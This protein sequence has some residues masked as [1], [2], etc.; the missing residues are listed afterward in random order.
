MRPFQKLIVEYRLF[1]DVIELVIP[2]SIADSYYRN[3]ER[4]VM[5]PFMQLLQKISA[6]IFLGAAFFVSGCTND[7]TATGEGDSTVVTAA[8][9]APSAAPGTNIVSGNRVLLTW[10]V[11][12]G[13]ADYRMHRGVQADGSDRGESP[14]ATV[15]STHYTDVGLTTGTSY[16]YWL[17]AC[18]SKGCSEFSPAANA[19]IVSPLLPTPGVAPSTPSTAPGTNIVNGNQILLTWDAV[20]GAADYRMHR[21]VQANGSDRSASPI[22]TV[23]STHYTDMGRTAG[24]T[25]YYWLRACNSTGCSAFSPAANAM[26][27]ASVLPIP[28]TAPSTPSAVPS[29]NIVNGNQILL[30]WA[31]VSGADDYRVHRGVQANGSD[32]SA[33]PIATVT[34]THYTDVGRTPGTSYYYWLRAC[35]STG[36]ST[37]SP[38]ANA[39][40]V[41]SLLPTPD[42][43]P[44]IP[45]LRAPV[46]DNYQQI[47]LTWNAVAGATRYVV[48]RINIEDGRP[49][50]NI[51]NVGSNA[52]VSGS[53]QGSTT[54][55]YSVQACNDDGCSMSSSSMAATTPVPPPPAPT[56]L[57]YNIDSIS[58]ISLSW[59]AV[60]TIT[61]YEIWRGLNSDNSDSQTIASESEAVTRTTYQDSALSV[62]TTY[63]YRLKSCNASGCSNFST[64][65][66]TRTRFSNTG[67][68]KIGANGQALA[69]QGTAWS[70]ANTAT[71]AAGTRWSCAEDGDTGLI[72]E[73]KSRN[74]SAPLQ[75]SPY[76]PSDNIH[77]SGNEYRW[78]GIGTIGTAGTHHGDWDSL[79]AGSN[80]EALCGFADGWR[81]PSFDE[82]LTLRFCS[83][84]AST[85]RPRC[86]SGSDRPTI[87]TAYFPNTISG[88]HLTITVTDTNGYIPI[89]FLNGTAAMGTVLRRSM[90]GS[91]RL[92]RGR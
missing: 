80:N 76:T 42:T 58:E 11:V 81:V 10:D 27:V 7:A 16:Y 88:N 45:Q 86:N 72:W 21:G 59:T 49:V 61:Y 17:R 38:A 68:T 28:G 51:F 57:R 22:A 12:S 43:V 71:E 66:T 92:V 35:N 30:T 67:F 20:S 46:V 90:R 44:A 15:A 84:E 25:Y 52:F 24:T 31:A 78:G 26:I 5:Y 36:C 70:N 41:S 82:L 60:P 29:T 77:H 3:L 48:Y 74:G 63:Y 56:G 14:V 4:F 8:P 40:I 69:I 39:M 55:E 53:L 37:F 91:V 65:L 87:N 9:S 19:M 32:R 18:N 83:L 89:N 73:V 33:S 54:Y 47:S 2:F 64:T 50:P 75:R 6:F 62:S 85:I 34:S 13:T 79:V 1:L 23:T